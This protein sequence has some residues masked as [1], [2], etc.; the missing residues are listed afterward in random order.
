MVYIVCITYMLL[1][2]LSSKEGFDSWIE[3]NSASQP[4]IKI[5]IY[6]RPSS[7]R[8]ANKTFHH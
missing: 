3:I 1:Y 7:A 8:A 2:L 6:K 4:Y 5:M